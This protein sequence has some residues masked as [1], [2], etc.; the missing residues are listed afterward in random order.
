M[1]SNTFKL[2]QLINMHFLDDDSFTSLFGDETLA[3]EKLMS[4]GALRET[5]VCVCGAK[6]ECI[7]NEK[8][9]TFRCN[10]NNCKAE[11]SLRIGSVFH[12]SS[13]QCRQIMRFARCWVKRESR[14]EAV[15][16]TLFNPEKITTWYQRFDM[17]VFQSKEE[18]A[19][20]IGGNE[21]IVEVDEM[22]LG[23]RKY[24]RG[25]RVEGAWVVNGVERTSKRRV[26]SVHVERRDAE[27]LRRVIS[28][29]VE[30]KSRVI[31][32]CWRGYIGIDKT[33]NVEHL[34]VNHSKEFKNSETGACTNTVKGI[35]NAFKMSVSPATVLI[36][37]HH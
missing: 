7:N 18:C 14:D 27:T 28:D 29:H 23:K 9:K 31:T 26:F 16:S 33:C 10:R 30:Q 36:H 3:L 8:K 25:H 15:K 11:V 22:K 34:T 12:E 2:I 13:K 20:R 4:V 21:I 6:M 24:N 32:D 17:L 1:S 5:Q 37:A 35:N 19:Q